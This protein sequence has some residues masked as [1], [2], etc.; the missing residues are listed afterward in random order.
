MG[1]DELEAKFQICMMAATIAAQQKCTAKFAA[2]LA[3]EIRDEV[4][5]IAENREKGD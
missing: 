5:Q 2:R 3:W 1:I 4:F